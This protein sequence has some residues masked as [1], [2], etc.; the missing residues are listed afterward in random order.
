MRG[1]APCAAPEPLA[2]AANW[3]AAS[4]DTGLL[5]ASGE[6]RTGTHAHIVCVPTAR[7]TAPRRNRGSRA[8]LLPTYASASEDAENAKPVEVGESGDKSGEQRDAQSLRDNS[9]P[10]LDGPT[11]MPIFPLDVV[12]LPMFEIPLH[13]FEAR[14]RALFNTLL[15]GNEGLDD[16]MIDETSPFL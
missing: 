14:Y 11:V 15:H 1:Q 16:A 13:I 12:A 5:T 4:K 9:G 2:A 6:G 8:M 3:A 7:F 10:T